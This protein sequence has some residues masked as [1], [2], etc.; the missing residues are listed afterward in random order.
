MSWRVY[1]ITMQK[2]LSGRNNSKESLW[3]ATLSFYPARKGD[4]VCGIEF[5]ERTTTKRPH[6][7]ALSNMDVH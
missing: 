6:R 2:N 5:T 4:I 3:C 7:R 1:G